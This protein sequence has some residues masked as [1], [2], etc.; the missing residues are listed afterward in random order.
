[1]KLNHI[2]LAVSREENADL[3]Y[4][5]LLGLKK[6]RTKTVSQDLAKTVFDLAQEYKVLD[7][8]DEELRF[9]LFIDPG[10]KVHVAHP[11]HL[12][13]DVD[14]REDFKSRASAL[15]FEVRQVPKG[16]RLLLF[17]KDFDGNLFEIK[18]KAV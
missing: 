18:A 7:Y 11:A 17:V 14:D 9:E 2:A 6:V 1:M 16:D 3:F 13:L 4:G 10:F 12:G 15:G 5:R 8:A